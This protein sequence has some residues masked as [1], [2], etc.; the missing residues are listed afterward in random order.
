MEQC[1]DFFNLRF[2][3]EGKTIGYVFGKIEDHKVELNISEY[4][5]FQTTLEQIFQTFANMTT[6]NDKAA[7]AFRMN[8]LDQLQLLNQDRR[9]TL[10]QVRLSQTGL[11]TTN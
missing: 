11:R 3:K 2:A 9:S 10:G 5:V 1:S 7:F 8:E 4:S 6:K